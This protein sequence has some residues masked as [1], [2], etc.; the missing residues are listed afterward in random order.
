MQGNRR[1]EVGFLNH[2]IKKN[3]NSQQKGQTTVLTTDYKRPLLLINIFCLFLFVVRT[4]IISAQQRSSKYRLDIVQFHSM[5][6]WVSNQLWPLNSHQK[7]NT[8][9]VILNPNTHFK[10]Y[11]FHIHS[12][13]RL[14]ISKVCWLQVEFE[15]TKGVIRIRKSKDRQ[16]NG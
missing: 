6:A 13:G 14:D 16:H 10:C 5:G 15:D 1:T 4:F 3:R 7:P 8:T 12:D 11:G 9:D 2:F